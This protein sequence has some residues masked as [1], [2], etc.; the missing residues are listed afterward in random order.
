MQDSS[1]RWTLLIGANVLCWC[2]LSFYQASDAAPRSTN[3][4]FANSI[5]QR[6]EMVAQLKEINAQLK[7][8][9]AILQ[10]GSLKVIVV[11]QNQR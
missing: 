4:P 10:S 8:Q 5:E 1:K 9:T 2:V 7:A 3:Q 11:Q 6:L